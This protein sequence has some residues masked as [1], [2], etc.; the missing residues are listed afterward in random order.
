MMLQAL[1]IVFL[2]M[3]LGYGIKVFKEE[4]QWSGVLISI[5]TAAMFSFLFAAATFALM[6]LVTIITLAAT[7][8]IG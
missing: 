1:A 6:F 7:G 2:V 8:F 3:W 4:Y 5:I